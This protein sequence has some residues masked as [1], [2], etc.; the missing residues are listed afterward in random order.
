M[1]DPSKVK[2]REEAFQ[3][4][5][6]MNLYVEIRKREKNLKNSKW[7]CLIRTIENP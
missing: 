1:E 3:L 4:Q 6:I 5:R 2:M 7:S